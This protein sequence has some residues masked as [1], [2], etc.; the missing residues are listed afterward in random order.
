MQDT[1]M[2]D[3][4]HSAASGWLAA[5]PGDVR[6]RIVVGMRWT[7][8][9]SALAVP[10]SYGTSIL[11][12]RTSPETLG[13]YG[14][15]MVYIGLVA[16][17]FYLGGDAVTIKFLPELAP[18]GHCAFLLSYFLVICVALVPWLVFAAGWP[19]GLRY[20]FGRDAG[21]AFYLGVLCLSPLYILFSMVN[22]TLKARLE[23]RL[24]Q[25]LT[26]LVTIGSF[27]IYACVFVTHRDWLARYPVEWIWSVY[28]GLTVTAAGIGLRHLWL[29]RAP[30]RHRV[31]RAF[32][33]PR[34]FWHFTLGTQQLS[35][36]GFFVQ[37][38]DYLL[39]LNFG[40][41]KLLGEYVAITTLALTIPLINRFFFETLLPS[42]TNLLAA[43]NSA[44]AAEVF[45]VHMRI[46]FLVSTATTCGLVLLAAPLTALFGTKYVHL[47]V[48]MLLLSLLVGLSGPGAAGGT[49]LSSI[50][51]PHRAI[52]VSLLQVGLY[53]ALFFALWP[54]DQLAGAVLAYGI[55][56]LVCNVAL[57]V[58]GTRSAPF[59]TLALR[60]YG[61]FG[62]VAVLAA[63]LGWRW[64]LHHLAFGLLAWVLLL[65]LFLLAD[66][67]RLAD[68]HE[69][70][71]WF[72]P[73]LP[74]ME[75][76]PRPKPVA[77]F[78]RRG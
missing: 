47:A 12:A 16:S 77:D 18:S 71:R 26:R 29:T 30:A 49:L 39:V 32:Y 13:I 44:G 60:D 40:G 17:V 15:L 28:L 24:A 46:I 70:A 50:G 31:R 43:G 57:F 9:L 67:F 27:L 52:W 45:R 23:L 11:L 63:I 21:S 22:A 7:V 58:V 48:P 37:R 56:L 1:S 65:M 4:H 72:L 34:G 8:W 69:L 35:F 33:L 64:T 74:R 5:V 25:L 6:E 14:I 54:R 36:L 66:D 68:C 55:A 38:L 41:T 20:L 51:K 73:W 10:F 42:L 61:A 59:P 75:T 78:W 19:G 2:T 53:T 3:E 62:A 76:R